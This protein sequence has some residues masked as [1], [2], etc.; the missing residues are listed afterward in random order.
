MRGFTTDKNIVTIRNVCQLLNTVA[1]CS[2]NEFKH[3]AL[4]YICLNLEAML[5]YRYVTVLIPVVLNYRLTRGRLL[6]ELDEDL[7]AELDDIV[8]QNQ[9]AYQPFAR[10]SRT[11][12]EMVERHPGILEEIEEAKRRRIDSM[13]LRSRLNA[14]EEERLVS[15]SKVKYGS[16]DGKASSPSASQLI[17][18]PS[19]SPGPSP[20]ILP[21]DSGQ[22]LLFE[23][24][25]E[26]E[27]AG[28]S[29]SEKGNVDVEG[30]PLSYAPLPPAALTGRH[31]EITQPPSVTSPLG[32][33]QSTPVKT[34]VDFKGILSEASA[35]NRAP[36]STSAVR[37]INLGSPSSAR[38]QAKMSQKDRKRLQKEQAQPQ[39]QPVAPKRDTD[40]LDTPPTPSKSPWQQNLDARRP[41]LGLPVT[42]T[43]RGP[44][45]ITASSPSTA[46]RPQSSRPDLDR[47]AASTTI[48]PRKSGHPQ[49]I[50]STSQPT[51]VSTQSPAPPPQ[52]QSIR[53]TPLPHSS[54]SLVNARTSMADILAQQQ[55]EKTAVKEAV[56]PRSLQEIQQEQE[57]QEWWDT[58]SRR[59]QEEDASG[60]PKTH[61]AKK[62]KADRGGRGG[63]RRRSRGRGG[64]GN[65]PAEPSSSARKASQGTVAN[66]RGGR[67]EGGPALRRGGARGS[68]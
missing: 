58:E 51:T 9:H 48:A 35:S 68:S 64:G 36:S 17:P 16:W 8:Q 56:A 39:P 22:D 52:I 53:H 43:A 54:R 25:V 57:F 21:S 45:A 5:E 34:K 62:D 32:W 59:M 24:E 44:V 13:R 14:E 7:L 11:Q 18:S 20:A 6:E 46:T 27:D 63:A 40:P 37:D 30:S 65:V 67:S 50:R 28:L 47:S 23:M 33:A 41:S 55:G 12:D 61:D 60:K 4:E 29:K 38:A 15:S 10:S 1:D 2:V 26:Q 3:V 31:E 42:N 19:S 49:P 66:A